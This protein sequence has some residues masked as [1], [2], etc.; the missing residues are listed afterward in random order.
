[1]AGC[2]GERQRGHACLTE[3]LPGELVLLFIYRLSLTKNGNKCFKTTRTGN[4]HIKNSGSY[5]TVMKV[6]SVTD[7]A[8]SAE[9][10]FLSASVY[11]FWDSG[12][13]HII[14]VTCLC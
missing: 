6:S 8:V 5:F 12:L 4:T 10:F 3:C 9:F 2:Y 7:R 14:S 11:K 13:E 1:M